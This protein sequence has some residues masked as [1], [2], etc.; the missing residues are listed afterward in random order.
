[1]AGLLL[2]PPRERGCNA[3]DQ[4]IECGIAP[5]FEKRFF[6]PTEK[7][8]LRISWLKLGIFSLILPLAAMRITVPSSLC[9]IL[10]YT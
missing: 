10:L 4:V 7:T 9:D 3:L 1:M 5:T 6:F 8:K 2:K